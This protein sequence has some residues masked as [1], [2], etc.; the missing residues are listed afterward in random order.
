[1]DNQQ[2]ADYIDQNRKNSVS[3]ADIKKSLVEA[4]WNSNEVDSALNTSSDQ[5]K[6]YINKWSW[7]AFVYAPIY[8]AINGAFGKGALYFLGM[9]VPLLNLFLPFRAAVHGREVA[10]Q[11]DT[12]KNFESF[13]KKQKILDRVG[14][15]IFSIE[16]LLIIDVLAVRFLHL[17]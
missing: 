5:A 1:M 10:W 4:G 9:G 3:D 13:C 16:L 6:T 14:I 12:R 8:F 17:S 11:N 15:V 2:L 7:G